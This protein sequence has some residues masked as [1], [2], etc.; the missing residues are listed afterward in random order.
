[1]KTFYLENILK[2]LVLGY[3]MVI[4]IEAKAFN[5]KV[6]KGSPVVLGKFVD[7]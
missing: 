7:L 5:S 2:L 3:I 4:G 1:M 6:T